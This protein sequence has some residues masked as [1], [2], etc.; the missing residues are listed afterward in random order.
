MTFSLFF[1]LPLDFQSNGFA[2]K[3]LYEDLHWIAILEKEMNGWI[4]L[5]SESV[6]YLCKRNREGEKSQST[7]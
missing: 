3:G 2:G 7:P 6:D 5:L 4:L 1:F